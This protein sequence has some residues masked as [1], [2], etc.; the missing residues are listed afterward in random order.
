LIVGFG[1]KSN[2]ITNP[3]AVFTFGALVVDDVTVD[4]VADDAGAVT[5]GVAVVVLE[6]EGAEL[7]VVVDVV[8]A[9]VSTVAGAE[10]V[11]W[12]DMLEVWV[13][14][15]GVVTAVAV[16]LTTLVG[17]TGLIG[18]TGDCTFVGFVTDL[19]QVF[20]VACHPLHT[21]LP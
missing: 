5:T 21:G 12:T 4:V 10:G 13:V 18:L 14:C 17:F 3:T 7:V 8:D 20:D 11:V 2:A 1:N 6:V 15:V 16:G 9:G 19:T